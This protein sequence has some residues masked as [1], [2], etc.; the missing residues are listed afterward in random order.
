VTALALKDRGAIGIADVDR[1]D[2][3][4]RFNDGDA[5]KLK[6]EIIQQAQF[7]LSAKGGEAEL[8]NE[9]INGAWYKRMIGSRQ[10]EDQEYQDIAT[11]IGSARLNKETRLALFDKML[12][13]KLSDLADSEEEGSP[14]RWSDRKVTDPERNLRS[15]LISEYRKIAP[16]TQ[17]SAMASL[18]FNQEQKI[19]DFFDKAPGGKRTQE[20]IDAFFKTKLMAEVGEMSGLANDDFYGV[21]Q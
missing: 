7:E 10:P 12:T 1:M 16:V 11:L 19:R 4:G 3:L 5:V 13:L 9:H 20:E 15:T 17:E 2:A 14:E 8:I 21:F 6:E 18:F